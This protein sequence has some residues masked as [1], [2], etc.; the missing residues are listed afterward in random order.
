MLESLMQLDASTI[1][2]RNEP[3]GTTTK[4]LLDPSPGNYKSI[5]MFFT[6]FNPE[7][8]SWILEP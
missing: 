4:H 7:K 5:A 8:E 1:G 2:S 6:N 3:T